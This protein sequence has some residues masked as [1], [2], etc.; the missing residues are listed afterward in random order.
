M[1]ARDGRG[2]AGGCPVSRIVRRGAVSADGS[3]QLL[4]DLTCD[5]AGYRVEA[6]PP[7]SRVLYSVAGLLTEADAKIAARVLARQFC[8]ER[9]FE[10]WGF[11]WQ[12]T[13]VTP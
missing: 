2:R 5:Q 6:S 11:G 8:R 12:S 3:V 1:A 13:E 9:G 4:V 7:G 10:T